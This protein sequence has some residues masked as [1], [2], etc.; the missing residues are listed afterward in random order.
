M[1]NPRGLYIYEDLTLTH[2]SN[3][4]EEAWLYNW[5]IPISVYSAAVFYTIYLIYI[6]HYLIIYHIHARALK[7]S[8]LQHK[9]LLLL[10]FLLLSLI[11]NFAHKGTNISGTEI[12]Q[13]QSTGPIYEIQ[14]FYIRIFFIT[15]RKVYTV[16]GCT[17]AER[18][19]SY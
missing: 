14:G 15:T 7:S 5:L 6:V 18:A 19:D 9:T 12:H 4:H 16:P 17:R 1:T 13:V 2:S 3:S 8:V 11:S 10:Y